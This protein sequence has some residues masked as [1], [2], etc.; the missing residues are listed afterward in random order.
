MEDVPALTL[1]RKEAQ[2]WK[3]ACR[4]YAWGKD[5]DGVSERWMRNTVA[6]KEVYVVEL[7]ARATRSYAF[8]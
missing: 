7:D 6:R 5:G 1:T 8:P 2:A 4:D 3:I